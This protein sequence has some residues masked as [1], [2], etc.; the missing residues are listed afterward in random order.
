MRPVLAA[1]PMVLRQESLTHCRVL[2]EVSKVVP[3]IRNKSTYNYMDRVVGGDLIRDRLTVNLVPD[4]LHRIN[5]SI[6]FQ[7]PRVHLISGIPKE[8]RYKPFTPAILVLAPTGEI[9][10][11]KF[12]LLRCF[13]IKHNGRVFDFDKCLI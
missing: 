7:V 5:G 11:S 8:S 13:L 10:V 12:L 3:K 6:L 4:L 9:F 1:D 2:N